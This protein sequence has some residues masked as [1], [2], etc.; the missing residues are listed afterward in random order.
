VPSMMPGQDTLLKCPTSGTPL[1]LIA[2]SRQYVHARCSTLLSKIGFA[3]LMSCR[4]GFSRSHEGRTAVGSVV[5]SSF[6]ERVLSPS[7]VPWFDRSAL[8]S[9]RYMCR[10]CRD[11]LRHPWLTSR[12]IQ[13]RRGRKI[14]I[15]GVTR[16]S[17]TGNSGDYPVAKVTLRTMLL[18][19][20]AIYRL[21]CPSARLPVGEFRAAHRRYGQVLHL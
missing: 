14:T 8:L 7:H 4:H 9:R 17:H 21:P 13:L 6:L 1:E 12:A 5:G 2:R 11:S 19:S 10:R 18:Y 16:D 20:S 15:V 3:R